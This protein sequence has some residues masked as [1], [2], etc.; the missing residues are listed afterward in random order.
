MR[1]EVFSFAACVLTAAVLVAGCGRSGSGTDSKLLAAG[2]SAIANSGCEACHMVGAEGNPGPGP[3]LTTIGKQLSPAEITS[4]LDDPRPPMPS[5]KNLP[6][7]QFKA[8][9]AYLA[10]LKSRQDVIAVADADVPHPVSLPISAALC[11][12]EKLVYPYLIARL[13]A[14]RATRQERAMFRQLAGMIGSTLR[15]CRH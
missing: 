4:A 15:A 8:I 14:Q 12:D 6:P 10:S 5:F 1:R 2:A 13:N 3:S 9:V 7:R 11:S